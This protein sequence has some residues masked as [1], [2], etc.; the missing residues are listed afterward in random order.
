MNS[1]LP[2]QRLCEEAIL[3]AREAGAYIQS[4][5]HSELEHSVKQ[6]GSSEASQIVTAVDRRSEAIILDRLL[7]LSEA[8]DIAF[9]GE[10]SHYEKGE[11]ASSSNPQH[12]PQHLRQ[13]FFW[14]VDPLD[15]TQPFVE[16]RPG[17]A[18]SIALVDQFGRSL[19]GVVYDPVDATMMHA[20]RGKGAYLD[21][22]LLA[23][24][25]LK[26]EPEIPTRLLV[27]AD[28]SFQ[29]H[30]AF[31]AAESGLNKCAA[32]LELDGVTF[33][34]GAGA[35]KN[36]CQVLNTAYACYPKL[37]KAEEGGGS[38]WDFAATAC[39]V[40]EAQGWASDI[41]GE[42]LALN[43]RESTFMNHKGVLYASN[44]QTA[45]CIIHALKPLELPSII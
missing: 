30:A 26:P 41:H 12:V 33:I 3:A 38:V 22:E 2:L 36:A 25:K 15:G 11:L 29:N 35:V 37:P 17:Y 42:A 14:C 20:I 13:S 44:E 21:G 5:D 8:W 7:P 16:G 10:E 28:S 32:L 1:S 18:V 43:R 24:T 31:K 9:L 45:R 23:P 34:V 19:M 6:A 4:I 39:I 40:S 27:Y